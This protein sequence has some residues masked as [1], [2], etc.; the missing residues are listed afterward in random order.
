MKCI[1]YG[2]GQSCPEGWDNFDSS[3]T[4][5]VQRLP[6]IGKYFARNS[7]WKVDP[8]IRRGDIV[9][10]LPVAEG[11]ADFIYCSHVL[12]N[13][14]L[15]E[16]TKALENTYR[17]LKGGGVFRGVL[18]DLREKAAEY[19]NSEN[20]EASHLFLQATLLGEKNREKTIKGILKFLFEGSKHRW[21]WDYPS[22]ELAL[23]NAGFRAVRRAQFSDSDWPCFRE[24]E[25]I[26]R[27]EGELGFEAIK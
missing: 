2:C 9:K 3:T 23:K 6:I 19:V 15:D 16:F 27:W 12:E 7:P 10:G 26:G 17:Y 8:R 25:D 1:Q 5:V 21:M 18:P 4:V 24:V 13:L 14:A 20:P 22:I 11:S